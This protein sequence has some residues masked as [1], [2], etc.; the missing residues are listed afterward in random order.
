MG[1]ARNTIVERF[2]KRDSECLLF[3][4]SDQ[5]FKPKNLFQ[6]LL[7]INADIAAGISFKK[8]YPY[9]PTIY[10]D[11]DGERFQPISN[12]PRNKIIE[13]DAVGM[14]CTLIKREVFERMKPPWFEFKKTKD[15]GELIGEDLVFCRKAKQLGFVIKVDT[16]LIIPHVGGIIDD[17]TFQHT[18]LALN[19]VHGKVKDLA[20]KFVSEMSKEDIERMVDISEEF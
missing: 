3:L 20:K 13:V 6:R 1:V 4:D 14:F 10:R 12:Y 16:S 7:D 17:R 8:A 19:L 11:Y 2:L 18:R 15:K 5:L 9:Y